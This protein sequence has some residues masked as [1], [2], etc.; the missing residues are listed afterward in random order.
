MSSSNIRNY[1]II[2]LLGL[3]PLL[4]AESK[5]VIPLDM[6]LIIDGSASFQDSQSD[7]L[8]WLNNQV[9]DR[10][11]MD[12]DRVTIWAA[13]DSAEVVF[14]GD[15][16]GRKEELKNTLASMSLTGRNADFSG[17]LVDAAARASRVSQD[18]LA[19]T[20]LITASAEGLERA[21]TG[22]ARELFRWFR[23]ERFE[24]WQV[25]VVGPDL[26]PRVREAAASYMRS[27][28]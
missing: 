9:V 28:Q 21:L 8:A 26:T 7:A 25:L 18:R 1:I 11:L 16:S 2:I 27:V 22:S 4:N 23:S 19:Y 20:M 5:R 14:S 6:F 12:G 13:G 24:R 17:A 10:I 15:I 3:A